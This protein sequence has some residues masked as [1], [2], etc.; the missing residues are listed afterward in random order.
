MLNS[1]GPK[2]GIHKTHRSLKLSIVLLATVTAGMVWY[3][4]SR[5]YHFLA[6]TPGVLYRSGWMKPHDLDKIIKKYGIKTVVNL[7]LSSEGTYLQNNNYLKEQQI[8]AGNGVELV[9]LPMV[10]N[11]PPSEEQIAEWLGLFKEPDKVPLLVHCAQGVT[12]TGAMVAVYEMELLHKDNK[13]TL[14][15]L[16]MFGHNLNDPKRARIRDFILNYKPP[17]IKEP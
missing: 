13:K 5:P 7:C 1:G 3:H 9:Y 15:E 12:R 14:K 16:P 4:K 6:V 2:F 17:H 10:G 11:T 8:C